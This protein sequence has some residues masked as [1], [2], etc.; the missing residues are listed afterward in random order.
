MRFL[1]VAALAA[2]TM[3]APQTF[4]KTE[5]IQY[6]ASYTYADLADL[7]ASAPVVADVAVTRATKLKREQAAGAPAGHQRFYVQGNVLSLIRGAQGLP[8]AVSWLVDIRVDAA[9]RPPKLRKARLILLAS[10]VA[11]RPGELRLAA[12]HAQLWWTAEL[13]QRLRA[14]IVAM[15]APDSPPRI[16][17]IAN[18]FHVPGSIPGESETQIFLTT[19]DRRPVSLNV[20]RRPGEQPRWAVALGDLVDEAAEPPARDTLLWYNLACF[21]PPSLPEAATAELEPQNTVAAREDYALII[22]GL[23]QCARNYGPKEAIS[24]P[25]PAQSG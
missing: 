13:D 15:N 23:G 24:T 12:P 6:I 8:G 16:T 19:A 2:A 14:I 3:T 9:N 4:A 20:L 5:R 22:A 1:L 10:T 18:A 21:L 17:G 7:A 25:T 11:G